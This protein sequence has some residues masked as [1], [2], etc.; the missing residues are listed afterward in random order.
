MGRILIQQSGQSSTADAH[1]AHLG[2]VA[3][4]VFGDT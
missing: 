1:R 2:H 3:E 4:P